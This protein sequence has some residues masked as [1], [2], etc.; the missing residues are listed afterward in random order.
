[1]RIIYLF[2][3]CKSGDGASLALYT[4]VNLDR[5]VCDDYL[6]VCKNNFSINSNLNIVE[7]DDTVRINTF[8]K[9]GVDLI[10][11]FK[12]SNS[13]IFK[14]ILRMVDKGIPVL[15][16]VCQ[17]PSYKR[18]ILSPYELRKSWHF[19]LIDKSS[20]TNSL[21]RFI[22]NIIKS[23]IYLV[24]G[25]NVEETSSVYLPHNK[26]LVI[27]GR[28]T[29][30]SKCP[31]NMFEIFDKIEVEN[32]RFYIAGI[33]EGDNWVRLEAKKR[34]NVKVF[35]QLPYQ[36]WFDLCKCFDVFLYQLPFDSYASIDGNLGLAMLMR[37]PVVFM[38]CDSPKERIIHMVNG[39]IAN[40]P[41]EMVMY[42]TRLGEDEELRTKIGAS[43]RE[44]TIKKFSVEQRQKAYVNIYSKIKK[45]DFFI[46]FRYRILYLFRCY[47]DIV[48][49]YLNYYNR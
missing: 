33:P 11:Y 29:T 38:G 7:I 46:P 5:V 44:T 19:V 40:N 45:H 43:A 26:P 39:F 13:N 10:H 14:S 18:Y 35:P 30:L 37:K 28:G 17:S 49:D 21:I 24:N 22:P 41:E 8:I 47:K 23:Q 20:Y 36:E 3:Y 1:M 34:I 25:N 42:A 4:Q 48:R 15:T 12:S 27:Y 9:S 31:K 16:T 6:V 2:S 32:K